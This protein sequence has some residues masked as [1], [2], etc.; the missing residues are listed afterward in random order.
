MVGRE[1]PLHNAEAPKPP[2]ALGCAE[3]FNDVAYV[4]PKL[5]LIARRECSDGN[6]SDISAIR[7]CA[8]I[9]T[10]THRRHKRLLWRRRCNSIWCLL[11]A[12]E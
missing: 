1:P 4:E 7:S 2:A 8:S 11:K 9:L 10:C 12:Q 5:I 3:H 6:L